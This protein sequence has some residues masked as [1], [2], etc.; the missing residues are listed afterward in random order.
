MLYCRKFPWI[1]LETRATTNPSMALQAKSFSSI[2]T[3]EPQLSRCG[4]TEEGSEADEKRRGEARR[5]RGGKEKKE[6]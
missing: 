1:G 4:L 6:R 5:G 3:T 2:I